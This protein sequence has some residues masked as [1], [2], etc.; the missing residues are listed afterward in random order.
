MADTHFHPLR[1]KAVRP[2]TEEAMIVT[3]QK[4]LDDH[5]A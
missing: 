5:R 2:D 1:V 4:R 3:F